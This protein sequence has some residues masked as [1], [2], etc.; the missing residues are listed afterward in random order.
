VI[1]LKNNKVL[2]LL[3]P[4]AMVAAI[5]LTFYF[6]FS[7]LGLLSPEGV[8]SFTESGGGHYVYILYVSLFVIQACCLSMIPGS[9]ALFCGAGLLIFGTDQFWTVVILNVIGAWFASQ[10]LFLIGRSGG[11][12]FIRFLFGENAFDKQL[13][14]LSTKGT[15]ILPIWFM[16]LI[17]PDDLMCMACGASRI[18]YKKF[19]ILHTVFRSI[20][21]TLLTTLYF[22]VIPV[23][24]NIGF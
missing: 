8:R 15:K 22:F 16:L 11:R 18:D 23:I 2:R 20:G 9:T 10:A 7:S 1:D 14:V 12:R 4:I 6:I 21:V 24:G 3:I 19:T 5:S 13:S 17:L